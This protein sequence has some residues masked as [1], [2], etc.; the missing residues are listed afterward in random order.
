MAS[1]SKGV[2]NIDGI[3]IYSILNIFIQQSLI[4]VPNLSTNSLNRLTRRYE[5]LQL[6]VINKI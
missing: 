6:V 1:T 3:T 2:F 4:S 5:Q